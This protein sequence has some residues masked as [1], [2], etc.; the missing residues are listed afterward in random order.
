[1][2]RATR[3]NRAFTLI[4]LLI[5]VAI[6]GI[7]ATVQF[8]L[9]IEGVRRHDRVTKRA[10]IQGEAR[11][12]LKSVGRD[13]RAAVEFPSEIPGKESSPDDF[14]VV[15]EGADGARHAVVYSALPGETIRAG[16]EGAEV[17][18]R[19][20]V[21]VREEWGLN[22][23]NGDR[24]LKRRVIARNVESFGCRL[25]R[26]LG[27]PVVNCSLTAAEVSDGRR[28]QVSLDSLFTPRMAEVPGRAEE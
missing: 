5:V 26:D 6:T 4:E 14:L 12:I 16:R 24:P 11:N 13:A 15:I 20:K 21:L 27:R 25:V 28:V 10:V 19:K 9:M 3:E 18:L 8:S 23:G 7:F 2:S 1:M 17:F 22:A